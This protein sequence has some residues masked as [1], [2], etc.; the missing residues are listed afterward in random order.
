MQTLHPST[1][2]LQGIANSH[3]Q[4]EQDTHFWLP[5]GGR[6]HVKL[7]P[8]YQHC[9]AFGAQDNTVSFFLYCV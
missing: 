1:D 7:L 5:S 2:R 6:S 9:L 3:R 8:E 4:P